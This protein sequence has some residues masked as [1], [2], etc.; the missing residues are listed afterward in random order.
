MTKSALGFTLV[1]LLV[2]IAIIGTLL[3]VLL[4]QLNRFNNEQVLKNTA[5]E[6]RSNIKKTQNNASSGLNCNN[7]GA[8][9]SQW[10]INFTKNAGIYAISAT[11]AKGEPSTSRSELFPSGIKINDIQIDDV[12]YTSASI[13]FDN[14]SSAINF[15]KESG[16][17]LPNADTIKIFLKDSNVVGIGSTVVLEKGGTVY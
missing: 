5:A 15:T 16:S 8:A 7:T 1:E 6:L 4:P 17:L 13:I 11:C 3:V 10:K 14:I 12:S 2:V 9:A